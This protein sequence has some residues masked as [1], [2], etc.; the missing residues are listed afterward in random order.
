MFLSV[1]KHKSCAPSEWSFPAFRQRQKSWSQSWQACRRTCEANCCFLRAPPAEQRGEFKRCCAQWKQSGVTY[2]SVAPSSWVPVGLDP[3]SPTWRVLD[4]ILPCIPTFKQ[5]NTEPLNRVGQ[6]LS[7]R[8]YTTCTT[9]GLMPFLSAMSM[10][11]TSVL[12]HRLLSIL[13]TC[14]RKRQRS[15]SWHGKQTLC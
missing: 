14:N 2:G 4:Q 8:S 12:S 5:K 15:A 1:R 10:W 6:N 13:W 3:S 11:T 7:P 9:L